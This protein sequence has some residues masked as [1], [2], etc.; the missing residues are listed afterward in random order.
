MLT[1]L[2]ATSFLPVTVSLKNPAVHYLHVTEALEITPAS[3][4]DLATYGAAVFRVTM[5]S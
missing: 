4:G 3:W 5:E 1:E 2:S